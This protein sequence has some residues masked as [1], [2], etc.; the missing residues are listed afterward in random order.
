MWVGEIMRK[1]IIIDKGLLPI[2]PLFNYSKIPMVKWSNPK[3]H[4][5]HKS[6]MKCIGEV[7]TNT[8]DRKEIRG[9][10]TGY[11]MLTGE[12]SGIMVV[13]IDKNHGNGLIDG[14][15]NF[16]EFISDLNDDDKQVVKDTFCVK[17]PREGVHLYFKYRSGLKNKANYIDGVDIRT[18]GGLIV[19]PN[20]EVVNDEI[21]GVYEV[22]NNNDILE[23]PE[24]LFNKLIEL[25]KPK[26]LA[27]NPTGNNINRFINDKYYKIVEEGGRDSTLASWLGHIIKQN[28]VMRNKENLLPHAH[29][30]NRCYFIPPLEDEEV[31][32]KVES[33]L[34]YAMPEYCDEKGKVDNWRLVNHILSNNP[35]YHKGNLY[36]LYDSEKGYYKHMDYRQVQTM[37][38]KYPIDDREK[39]A[40]KAKSF[41]DLLMLVSE[42]AGEIY[43]E[44]NYINCLNGIIDIKNDKLI[45][46]DSKYKLEVQFKANYIDDWKAKFEKS[47]FKTYLDSTL[48]DGS[49]ITLQESW[50]LMLSPHAKEVQSC[51][52]YKGEGSN[53]KS[54][55]FEIQEALIG[56]N[57]HICSIG[58]GD[59][60]GE[61][62]ISSAEG[63]HVN[64]VRDDELTDKKVNKSFKSMCCG[65]PVQVNRKNKDIIRLG[66]NMTMFFGV[67]TLPESDDNSDG[68]YRRPVIIPFNNSFGTAEEVT[69][70]IRDRIKDVELAKKIIENEIDIVFM[71]AYEGLKRLKKN[72]WKVTISNASLQEKEEYRKESDNTYAFFKEKI[73]KLPKGS[74]RITKAELHNAYEQWCYRNGFKPLTI[75]DFGKKFSK[76]GIKSFSSN[77][78]RYWVDIK[79]I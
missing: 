59:F 53:G 60:G 71:W 50:G 14:I 28:P 32:K 43:D 20:S 13:D 19:L 38:F 52:I 78:M 17:T 44:K 21:M 37:F 61:F 46:H 51:F 56:N 26:K 58:L 22:V 41:S 64:I 63:K 77:S 7:Y 47:V 75:N 9:V 39:T 48:D 10:V 25:D 11:S 35:S 68:Y 49:I 73:V 65:E 18:D 40:N 62:V 55:A 12:K 66:F 54:L 57:E 30:Y 76:H 3:C 69:N 24:S 33:I 4:I 79:V 27:I 31:E 74:S 34:R 23:M 5:Q 16:E 67:N 42:N 29:M 6:E 70:G 8:I 15:S 72:K 2:I 1:N 45:P 36:Y